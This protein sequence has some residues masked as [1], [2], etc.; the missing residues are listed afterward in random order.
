[1]AEE[2][3]PGYVI[4]LFTGSE[5]ETHPGKPCVMDVLGP[6]TRAESDTVMKDYLRDAPWTAPHRV[7]LSPQSR[8]RYWREHQQVT[9]PV[10]P[11]PPHP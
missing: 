6:M 7:T 9:G 2:P 3:T 10:A 8:L 5:C 1:M 11:L 4:V